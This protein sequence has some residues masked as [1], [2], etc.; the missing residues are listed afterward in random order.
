MRDP[1]E[2]SE[3]VRESKG[4]DSGE[5]INHKPNILATTVTNS[6]VIL[7]GMD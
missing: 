3:N 6:M 2:P 1:L 4:V 7:I 5:V